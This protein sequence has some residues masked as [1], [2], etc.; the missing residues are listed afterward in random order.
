MLHWC[1]TKA[2]ARNSI[3]K[4]VGKVPQGTVFPK[5]V[6]WPPGTATHSCAFTQFPKPNASGKRIPGCKI[7][8]NYN[9]LV[10]EAKDN[11]LGSCTSLVQPSPNDIQKVGA[12]IK[13]S[14][15]MFIKED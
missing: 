13:F 3:T 8:E 15:V 6:A 5:Y 7:F 1:S 11:L 9:H 10:L 14:S 4:M 2:M 12:F